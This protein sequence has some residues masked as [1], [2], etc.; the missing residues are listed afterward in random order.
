MTRSKNPPYVKLNAMIL[1][2]RR[3]ALELD[4][5]KLPLEILL[6]PSISTAHTAYSAVITPCFF[7]DKNRHLTKVRVKGFTASNYDLTARI[8]QHGRHTAL[9]EF[10]SMR[11]NLELPKPR[12]CH[13]APPYARHR[14]PDQ[15][16]RSTPPDSGEGVLKCI[17]G[18]L[19]DISLGALHGSIDTPLLVMVSTQDAIQPSSRTIKVKYPSQLIA[20]S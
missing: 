16:Y 6:I 9:E 11:E 14:E 12:R 3:N 2:S 7:P 4:S 10:W 15:L 8:V 18:I 19:F 17:D 20:Y 1:S 5:M 13:S